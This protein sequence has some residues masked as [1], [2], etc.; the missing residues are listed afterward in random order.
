M[1]CISLFDLLE[2]SQSGR[3]PES[4]QT[5]FIFPGDF[6]ALSEFMYM[7]IDV[8][9]IKYSCHENCGKYNHVIK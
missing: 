3:K 6:E 1:G 9:L 5:V 4:C 8:K 7:E 2:H